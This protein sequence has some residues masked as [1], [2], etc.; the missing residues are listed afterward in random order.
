MKI[1]RIAGAV[2]LAVGLLMTTAAFAANKGS[3]KL[4]DTASAA[5]KQIPAGQY[6]VIW[7]GNGP[8]VDV[9]IMK[10]SQVIATMPGRVV[11]LKQAPANDGTTT[12]AAGGQGSV[13]TEIFFRGKTQALAID[14]GATE[15]AGGK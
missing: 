6:T 8:S 7:E 14:M 1:G 12:K 3:M 2:M 5:G 10:G 9:K 13:L 15:V 4:F 11:D